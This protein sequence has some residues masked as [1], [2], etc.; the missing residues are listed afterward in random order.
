[1]AQIK[2]NLTMIKSVITFILTAG[3]TLLTVI[4]TLERTIQNG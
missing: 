3:N 2:L 1:M 4:E